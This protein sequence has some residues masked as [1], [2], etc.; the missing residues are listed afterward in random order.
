MS[1]ETLKTEIK[2]KFRTISRFSEISGIPERDL[3]YLLSGKM[4]P[5]R[6][7]SLEKDIRKTVR[8]LEDYP[9]PRFITEFEREIVR[10][11]IV[12][13]FRSIRRFAEEYPEFSIAFVSNVITGRRKIRTDRFESLLRILSKNKKSIR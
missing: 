10:R 11:S 1:I 2:S 4:T 13:N 6:S 8:S 12:V 3:R 7:G 9:D 5:T